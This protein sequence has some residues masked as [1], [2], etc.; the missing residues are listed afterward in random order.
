MVR[1]DYKQR[2]RGPLRLLAVMLLLS[3]CGGREAT[4]TAATASDSSHSAAQPSH[5]L[6]A[7]SPTTANTSDPRARSSQDVLDGAMKPDEPGCSAAVGIEGNVVWTG[8][9]GIANLATGAEITPATVFDIGST[10]KQFTATAILLLVQA[11]KLTLDDSLSQHVP[12][13]PAWAASVTVAQ[14][15]HHTSGIPDYIGLLRA[16]GYQYSDHTTQDQALKALA[17]APNLEFEPGTKY[18]YSNSNYLLLGEI[19]HQVSGQPLPEFL[20]AQ[21]FRPLGL[22][23][24]MSPNAK[25]PDKA[26]S[27][28]KGDSGAY[29]VADSHWEQVGDGGIQT[30]ATQLVRWADNYRTGK[31]GGQTLLD[32][33]LAGAVKTEPGGEER[34]GAGIAL[35]ADGTLEHDGA[36]AGFL[37]DFR[38]SKDRRTSVA[39]SCNADSRNPAAI[40]ESLGHLW[41]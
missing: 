28:E 2:M 10:S 36:W 6:G 30:T 13:L 12:G 20:N 8:V 33:Q 21:I 23:M 9:R 27:Y 41:M 34:Y 37:T 17:A 22:A 1:I 39:V 29:S 5:A 3:A 11:G 14:L 18:E 40:A 15:M 35:R 38:I 24:V 31:V 19:V 4:P 16:E 32:A 26:L 25:L 7:T